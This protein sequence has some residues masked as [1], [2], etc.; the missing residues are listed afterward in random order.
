[1]P[2][3]LLLSNLVELEGQT[4]LRELVGL[5]FFKNCMQGN[6]IAIYEKQTCSFYSTSRT[7]TV[8]G[9]KLQIRLYFYSSWQY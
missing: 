6:T 7:R 4:I 8:L 9:R 2:G 1:M 3:L 5:A